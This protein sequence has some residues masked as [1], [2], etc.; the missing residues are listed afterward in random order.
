MA[1]F[2]VLGGTASKILAKKIAQKLK[3]Q[4][5]DVNLKV[6]P[7]GECKITLDTK[8]TKGKIVVVQSTYPPVDT[9]L[10]QA[11]LLIS[12][13]REINSEV[14]AVIP[15][16]GY[17]KQDKEFLRGEIITI[18]VVAKLFKAMGASKIIVVDIHDAAELKYFKPQTKNLS[19]ISELAKYFKSLKL[20]EPIVVSP[21]LFWGT[22]AKEFSKILNAPSF[23]LNKQRDR[24]TGKLTIR[25]GRPKI[26]KGCDLIFLDD[27][28]STGNSIV[29]AIK[30]LRKNNF[31]KIYVACTHAVLAG[32]AEKKILKAG[33]HK[34]ISTNTIP[35]KF[36]IVDLSEIIA[37]EIKNW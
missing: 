24:R 13:A 22:K 12:K 11:F 9:H 15:Y 20:K 1:T 4:Y 26:K 5:L 18:S 28:I 23:A 14:I 37:K 25:S 33:A 2:T 29:Q 17:A 27:M 35:G 36:G 6:F 19:A 32:D 34:I 10:I 21:D 7:D 30:F 3:A 8:P 31:R 16:M